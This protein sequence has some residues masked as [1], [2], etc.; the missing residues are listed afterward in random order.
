M[1][2]KWNSSEALMLQAIFPELHDLK[3]VHSISTSEQDLVWSGTL[4]QMLVT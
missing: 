3:E 1:L 4:L 2:W